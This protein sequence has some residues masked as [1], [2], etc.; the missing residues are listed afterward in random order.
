VLTDKGDPKLAEQPLDAVY[1][2][3]TYHLLFH[4]PTLLGKLRERLTDSGCV[5]VLDR[6]SPDE[7]S[8]R[9]ASHRRMI[10]AATVKKE[11]ADAGFQLLR[12]EPQPA[13]DRFLLVFGKVR[14]TGSGDSP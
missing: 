2:L 8:H 5:Y 9:E 14:S 10:A 4:G 1:F 11:M 3:D 6:T 13:P 12:E 7:I